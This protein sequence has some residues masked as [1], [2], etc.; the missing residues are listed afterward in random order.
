MNPQQ[1]SPRT[2]RRAWFSVSLIALFTPGVLFILGLGLVRDRPRFEWLGDVARFP[3]EVWTIALAGSIATASGVLDWRFHRSG[4]TVIG[5][6]EHRSEVAALAS[7]GVPLFAL[8]SAASVSNRPALWLIPI[9]VVVIYVTVL[10]CFDEFVYHRRRCGRY[11]TMLH[12]LL[13]FGNGT[14]WLAWMHWCFVRGTGH[15]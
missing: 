1:F 13:V 2:Q 4:H 3:W 11:E 10:I 7:G 14:A 12:R 8:M 6:A 15:V 9:L 5:R